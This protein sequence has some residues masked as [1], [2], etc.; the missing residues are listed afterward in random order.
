MNKHEQAP[1]IQSDRLSMR[2]LS[3]ADEEFYCSLYTDAEVMRFAGAALSRDVATE[4]F[5]KSLGR[6]SV[7]TF[8]RRV[9]LLLDRTTQEPIGIS[10]VRLLRG[11]PGRAEV[12][13]LLKPGKHEK[14][15]AQECSIALITQAFTRPEIH[16]LVAYST[17][18]NAAVESLLTGLGFSREK[19]VPAHDG[20]P[21]RI[22]WSISRGEWAKR[23]A[24]P[25]SK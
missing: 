8:E 14:G 23:N 20:Q 10:S 16:E 7:S 25:K 11:K 15:F 4:S 22:A 5:R 21:E 17:P 18:G 19:S 1:T 6:M 24:G 2:S 3:T 12:G 13:T 9:V